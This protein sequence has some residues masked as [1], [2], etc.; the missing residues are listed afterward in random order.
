MRNL[1][2]LF[3]LVVFNNLTAQENTSV[4][5]NIKFKNFA[6]KDGLS[7]ISVT[8]IAQDKKG[9][10]WFGTR[11]GLNKFDGYV[12]KNYNYRAKD[13][14]SLSNNWI[15]SIVSDSKG[16][17]WIG[18]KKGLNKYEPK[19]NNFTRIKIPKDKNYYEKEITNIFVKDSTFLIISTNEG[20][21]FFDLQKNTFSET[22]FKKEIQRNISSN[23]IKKVL[24]ASNGD[25]FIANT[26]KIDV[27]KKSV[28][29]WF[30]VSY[31]NNITLSLNTSVALHEDFDGKILLGYTEGL[32][33]FD[34]EEK[35]F[36]P[37]IIKS[38]Q[39]I[40]DPI[41]DIIHDNKKNLWIGTYTGLFKLDV[42]KNLTKYT[43]NISN[44]ESLSQNS[45]Y[46][47]FLDFNDGLWVGTWAGGISYY[48]KNNNNFLTYKEG[49]NQNNLNYKV[50]SS[51]L[52]YDSDNLW[53]GT[54]GG[55]INIFNKESNSFRFLKHDPKNNNSLSSNNVK[56]I[57]KDF[58]GDIWVGTHG[59]GVN[60][61]IEKNQ[62]IKVIRYNELSDN[63]ITTFFEDYK[64]NIWIGTN[65]GGLNFYDRKTN[66]F[67]VVIN[68]KKI[69]SFIYQL[70]MADKDH[71]YVASNNGLFLLNMTTKQSQEIS[72]RTH[73]KSAFSINTVTSIF[74]DKNT[75]WIG[76]AGDGLYN[77]DLDSKKSIKYGLDNGLIDEFIHS[78]LIDDSGSLWI[79]TNKGISKIDI[80][81]NKIKNFKQEDGLQSNEF[82]FNASLKTK[83]GDLLFGGIEGFTYFNPQKIEQ[84]QFIPPITITSFQLR[85]NSENAFLNSSKDLVLEHDQNYFNIEYI[86]LDYSK[87]TKIMYAYILEGF[88]ESWNYVGNKKTASYTNLKPGNYT[89]KVKA[90]NTEGDWI[91][92]NQVSFK[93]AIKRAFWETYWA[94]SFYFLVIFSLFW[95]I[96]KYEVLRIKNK[97]DLEQERLDKDQLKEINKLKLQLFTNISHDFRTPLTLIIGPL[98]Q[99]IKEN[100]VGEE[101][102]KKLDLMYRNAKTLLELINQLLDFRKSEAG[103]LTISAKKIDLKKFFED[104]KLAFEELAARR[105]IHYKLRISEE[106]NDVWFDKIEM[107]K[108]VL[109][110]LSNAFKFTPKSGIIS[111]KIKYA[112]QSKS[113][114]EIIISNT[115]KGIPSEDL[116]NIFDRYFQLGQKNEYRSGTGVGLALAKD[117][118]ELHH[119]KITVKSK[120]NKGTVFTISLLSGNSHFKETEIDGTENF[121][122]IE[123]D[124]N[125]YD[126][127]A[128]VKPGWVRTKSVSN[129]FEINAQLHTILIVEDN[130]EV[131][132]FIY[133]I[134]KDSF[135]VIL[136]SNGI[137]G[138]E[139][140]RNHD[141]DVI[142]SD[143]MMPEM[144]GLEMCENLKSD[145]RTSHIPVIMLTARTSSK[146]Q[147]K[148]YETGA[149]IY[150]TKPFNAETLK[151]QVNNILNSRKSLIEK[152]KKDILIEPKE[153]TVVSAD[154]EFLHKAMQIIE[155]NFANPD[156][157]VNSFTEK[158]FMSQSL[159][160]RKIK[161]LTGQSISEFIRTVRLK[162]ACQ[163]LQ[164]TDLP[165]KN[166]VYDI[167]FNDI[168]YFRKC[169]N[170]LFHMTPSEYRKINK[171]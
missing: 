126:G 127:F 128:D 131:R 81:S 163:L 124:F 59:G 125:D 149:D 155:E 103:K 72:F 50:V 73:S 140:S 147:K 114:I 104:C 118:V 48:S 135:N 94:Y 156:F 62:S 32:V 36:K 113:N 133:E 142:V 58:Y 136:A 95:L 107:K 161:I 80:K 16:N 112:L 70:I 115:G 146:V 38:N 47:I 85:N 66:T 82:N 18:T 148:G 139:F 79:S 87:P 167:G 8:S 39:V 152:F 64:T 105:N 51:F 7:Q 143:L 28:H 168:K 29:K 67:S 99:L 160:Y 11:Y 91:A 44:S 34:E 71:L 170:E 54:E 1:R 116:E 21:D 26:I 89:F 90:S 2:F 134:F 74:K 97:H 12:F 24:L 17:L 122:D 78:I 102:Q 169:F 37:L 40:S 5:G 93:L 141:V 4:R 77:Y 92:Q 53:I 75:L 10:M 22:P 111:I 19:S 3:L 157:N 35:F 159:L 132:N 6:T 45:I 31:P 120:I 61:I 119:G 130:N 171:T 13:S 84:D 129:N 165:V 65:E 49:F 117:I 137:E 60:R 63:R 15:T 138:L 69:G 154:E 14:N 96:R 145:I 30:S 20:V 23:Y 83:E 110:I 158:M 150:I 33:Y 52:Q 100:K 108:V 41:R 164:K 42:N 151:L 9:F 98:E 27:Y 101:V 46:D 57:L 109:N 144:D 43:H 153:I 88:E 123:N 162:K 166:I 106:I 76:T 55:G 121:E 56:A 86:A 68:N 25:V